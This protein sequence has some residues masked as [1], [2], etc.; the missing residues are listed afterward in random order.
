MMRGK[1][2][3]SFVGSA[4]AVGGSAAADL[5]VE[6]SPGGGPSVRGDRTDGC[7]A[8]AILGT[9]RH[10]VTVVASAPCGDRPPSGQRPRKK[11]RIGGLPEKRPAAL[12]GRGSTQH[13][14][15]QGE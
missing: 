6:V 2:R 7:L 5:R 12:S 1:N 14:L 11:G 13:V 15:Q 4:M 8:S 10:G 3:T 9:A